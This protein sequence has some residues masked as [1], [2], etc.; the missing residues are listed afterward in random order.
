ML[1]PGHDMLQTELLEY[2]LPPELIATRPAEPR[3]AARL[4]VVRVSDDRVEHAVCRDLPEFLEAGDALVLNTTAV[5]PARLRGRRAATGGRVDALFLDETAP[6]RWSVMLSSGGRLRPGDRIDLLDARG[7]PG[8]SGLELLEPGPDGWIARLTGPYETAA[9]LERLGL[10]PLPPYILKARRDAAAVPDARDRAWYQTVYADPARRRSVAAPTAGLHF[11]PG[12]L[13]RL[14]ERGVRR[15]DVTLHVGPGTFRPIAAA[16][17]EQHD[18]HAEQYEVPASAVAALR[19]TPGRVIAV[20]ST[21]I[22]TLESL[23]KSLSDGP[24][25]GRTDLLIAPPYELKHADGLL[26]NFHLPRTTLLAL[27]AA[28]VGLDRLHALYREAI[29]RRYRFYSYGDAML[30]LP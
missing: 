23:P 8:D 5:A 22:R 3:D 2:D 4:M 20:G 12:L 15:I 19:E 14:A 25:R 1:L 7:R 28:L 16:S 24:F 17:V 10:T 27:V 11:T 29:R 6:R 13:D 30:V 9:V 21:A 18:M 26:T